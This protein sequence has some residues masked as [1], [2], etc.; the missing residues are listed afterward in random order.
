MRSTDGSSGNRLEAD[1]HN[2]Q[3]CQHWQQSNYVHY[4][5]Y[6][7]QRH[8]EGGHFVHEKQFH[9]GDFAALGKEIGK[10]RNY[11]SNGS[12]PREGDLRSYGDEV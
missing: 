5:H 9:K 4:V 11:F 8:H 12:G 3:G 1:R 2:H 10:S 7:N 6:A